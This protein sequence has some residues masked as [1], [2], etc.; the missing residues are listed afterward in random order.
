MHEDIGL[1]S[2][3]HAIETNQNTQEIHHFVKVFL[4]QQHHFPTST[5]NFNLND[6]RCKQ[7]LGKTSKPSGLNPNEPSFV[8]GQ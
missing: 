8:Y 5:N 4:K 7:T 2:E 3:S 6:H 1:F